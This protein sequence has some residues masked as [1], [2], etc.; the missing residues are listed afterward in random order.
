MHAPR[1]EYRRKLPYSIICQMY[2]VC[3]GQKLTIKSQMS[4]NLRLAS[5]T[6]LRTAVLYIVIDVHQYIG[7]IYETVHD[8]CHDK[9]GSHI[10]QRMLFDEN[11]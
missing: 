3:I 2:S 6:I 1:G 9:C 7:T 11:S 4:S 10:K 5:P 8:A